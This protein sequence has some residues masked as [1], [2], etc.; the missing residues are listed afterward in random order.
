MISNKKIDEEN[1]SEP[2][3]QS[4]FKLAKTYHFNKHK[5]VS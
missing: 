5:T 4:E 1:L 3:N 2:W